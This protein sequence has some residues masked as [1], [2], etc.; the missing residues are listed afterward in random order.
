MKCNFGLTLLVLS[1]AGVYAAPAHAVVEFHEAGANASS[2][3]QGALPAF[4][5]NVRKRPLAVQ[6][7]GVASAYVTCSFSTQYDFDNQAKISYFGVFLVNLT[8]ST[9]NV[10]CTG[11]AGYAS[12]STNVYIGKNVNIAPNS[13]GEIFFDPTD[14]G[15]LLYD[16]MVNVSC[17]IPVGV[18]IADTHVGF[19]EDDA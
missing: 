14:N 18:G 19:E 1:I 8:G 12:S 15:D 3:C 16:A 10:T 5:T 17:N 9:K 4:E 2:L 7:E 11:V 13:E 6:N